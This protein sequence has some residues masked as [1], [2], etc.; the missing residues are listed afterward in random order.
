MLEAS[1]NNH[2]Q[3]KFIDC[4]WKKVYHPEKYKLGCLIFNRYSLCNNG[5]DHLFPEDLR[6]GKVNYNV[7]RIEPTRKSPS[8]LSIIEF[9]IK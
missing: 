3:F 1:E 4:S 5:I 2:D 8:F 9:L 6:K 7:K